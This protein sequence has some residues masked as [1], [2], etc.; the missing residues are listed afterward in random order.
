[1]FTFDKNG[2]LYNGGLELCDGGVIKP[3]T[4]YYRLSIITFWLQNTTLHKC[5]QPLS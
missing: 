3:I 1:M 2:F 5:V 4:L